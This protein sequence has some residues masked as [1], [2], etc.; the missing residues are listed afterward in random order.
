MQNIQLLSHCN[1]GLACVCKYIGKIDEQN[2][3]VT[4]FNG[5]SGQLVNRYIHLHN[6]KVATSKIFEDKAREKDRDNKK[7][8]GHA[9][10]QNE[11]V[12]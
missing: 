11:M 8:H 10:G 9:I 4:K 2:F 5:G 1:G 7:P 12:H 3:V 6:T